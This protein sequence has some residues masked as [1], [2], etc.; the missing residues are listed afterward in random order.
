MTAGQ[1]GVVHTDNYCL[2]VHHEREKPKDEACGGS[3]RIQQASEAMCLLFHFGWRYNLSRYHAAGSVTQTSILIG[4]DLEE[5]SRQPLRM[6]HCTS[7]KLLPP[8]LAFLISRPA[9]GFQQHGRRHPSPCRPCSVGS[10]DTRIS[11][12]IIQRG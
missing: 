2:S 4:R 12:P 3:G 6:P 11:C 8:L 9:I 5:M 7:S 1:L 10:R